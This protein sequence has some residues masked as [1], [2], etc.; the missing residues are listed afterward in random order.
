MAWVESSTSRRRTNT[1]A[2]RTAATARIHLPSGRRALGRFK[3][4]S[5]TLREGPEP[6]LGAKNPTP[7]RQLRFTDRAQQRGMVQPREGIHQ[8]RIEL[9]AGLVEDLIHRL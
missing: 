8:A 7:A 2:N 9:R 4:P 6:G 3:P 1:P 5:S